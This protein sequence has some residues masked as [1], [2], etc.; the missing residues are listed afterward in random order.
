MQVSE[1]MES[2]GILL[3]GQT[4]VH[5]KEKETLDGAVDF[6]GAVW[7]VDVA[8]TIF[9]TRDALAVSATPFR[10]GLASYKP[11]KGPN[12]TVSVRE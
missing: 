9:R 8:I 5:D 1:E 2:I 7:T 10:I 12:T 6:V 3:N 11:P 4:N